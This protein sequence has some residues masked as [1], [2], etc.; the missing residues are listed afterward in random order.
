MK[1]KSARNLVRETARD[2]LSLQ[3]SSKLEASLSHGHIPLVDGARIVDR[4]FKLRHILHAFASLS[5]GLATTL[6]L[7][8]S[9][10]VSAYRKSKWSSGTGSILSKDPR[11][12]VFT[13]LKLLKKYT[14]RFP[15]H[16]FKFLSNYLFIFDLRKRDKYEEQNLSILPIE[17]HTCIKPKHII[18]ETLQIC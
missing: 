13:L 18:Q 14:Y 7:L 16:T 6:L 11:A 4:G 17:S 3:V 1:K 2:A 10:K 12:S 9:R 5:F 15:V 8:I